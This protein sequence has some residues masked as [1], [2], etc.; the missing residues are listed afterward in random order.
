MKYCKD[1]LFHKASYA[2]QSLC[3]QACHTFE[4]IQCHT[5]GALITDEEGEW[6]KWAGQSPQHGIFGGFNHVRVQ[7]EP[8]AE[9]SGQQGK[10]TVSLV[11]LPVPLFLS[12]HFL[13]FSSFVPISGHCALCQA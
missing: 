9:G 1:I 12:R 10:M 8:T 7:K 6:G 11:L 5:V 13:S 4:T 3:S 2:K